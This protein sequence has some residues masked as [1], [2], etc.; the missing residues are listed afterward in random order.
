[1]LTAIA[2]VDFF[3]IAVCVVPAIILSDFIIVSD[4]TSIAEVVDASARVA[5]SASIIPVFIEKKVKKI[6]M[7]YFHTYEYTI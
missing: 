1:M 5:T 3:I 6:S 7:E 2:A 4:I